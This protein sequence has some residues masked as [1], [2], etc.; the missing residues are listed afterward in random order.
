M[1]G[2]TENMADNYWGKYT[3]RRVSRRKML[4]TTGLAGAAAGAVLVVGCG[5]GDDE[6]KGTPAAG[7]SPTGGTPVVEATSKPSGLEVLNEKNPPVPG[8]RL[9]LSTGA[10]FGTW[11]P[12]I[13]VA[14]AANYFPQVYNLLVNQSTLDASYYFNDLSESNETPD[15]NTW[16]FK[17]RKGVKVGP[18]D[19]GVPERDL[20]ADDARATY[21]RIKDEPKAGNGAIKPFLDTVSAAGDIFTIKTTKPYAWLLYRAG[22]FTST[23]PPKELLADADS[24]AKMSTKSA[25]GGPFRLSSST[26]GEV[27]KMDANPSYYRKDDRN[28]NAALPYRAGIDLLVIRDRAAVRTA[29]LNSNFDEAIHIYGAESKQDADDVASNGN[30][31]ITKDPA[32]TFIAFTMNP[33]KPPFTDERVRKAVGFAINRQ[34]IVDL[35]YG[36]DAEANG[37][38]HWPMGDYAYRGEELKAIQPYDVA[39]AKKLV[40]AVGGIKFK[41]MY[42]SASNIQQH[43]Q[44]LPIFLQQMA[45]AGIEIEQDP[46]D[47]GTWYANYQ[48]LN[49][50]ASLS[51]N[52]SY[53]TPEV[54]IDFQSAGGPLSDRSFAIG[55]QGDAEIDAAILKTKQAFDVEERIQAVR[56]AQ[57]LIYAKGPT[58]L[59][60][61][62]PFGY[63][64]YNKRLRNIITGLGPATNALANVA[65]WIEA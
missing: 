61:V 17:I 25:G 20:D 19:L 12:H 9:R 63:T 43:D 24:I 16:N 32:T 50:V 6:P 30:S 1:K 65:S 55:L 56:D 57:K 5:G 2:D 37:L 58:F 36:G 31:F 27:A 14:A 3:N 28:S 44:H 10:D 26:E 45:D 52:Q 4:Q 22:I 60:L 23:I 46:I 39:E 33:E 18:N 35:V 21:Q 62:T 15:E 7:K 64:V 47:F 49:Y 8:G 41:M 51:L 54:P 29:F 13:S 11:D 53:E 48:T 38:V 40:E 42:P 59:P 34:Q